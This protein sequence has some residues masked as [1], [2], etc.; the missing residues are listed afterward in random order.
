M[1]FLKQF[2][3]DEIVFII[4]DEIIDNSLV[5]KIISNI[6]PNCKIGLDMRNVKA[7]KSSLFIKY[8]NKEKYSL[9]NLRNEV[10][11]YLSLIIK[12]GR[13]KSFMNY[14]DFKENKRELIRRRFIIA[15]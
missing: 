8:L 4:D 2:T 15:R 9:Y 12:N 3:K 7:L 11:T 14:K 1:G 5:R 13:L 6:K 10:M